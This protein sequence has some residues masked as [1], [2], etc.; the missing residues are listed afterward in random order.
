MHFEELEP[1]YPIN[2]H[3]MDDPDTMYHN[4]IER[5]DTLS[6]HLVK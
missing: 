6:N 1:I 2:Q 3:I 4:L 5:M